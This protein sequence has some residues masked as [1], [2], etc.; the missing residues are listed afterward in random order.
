MGKAETSWK[1]LTFPS[2]GGNGHLPCPTLFLHVLGQICLGD[3]GV[4]MVSAEALS[5]AR[6]QAAPPSA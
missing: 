2:C 6:L 1:F 3:T 5:V 4:S